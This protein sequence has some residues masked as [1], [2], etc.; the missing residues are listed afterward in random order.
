MEANFLMR[1]ALT[2]MKSEEAVEGIIEMFRRTKSNQEFIQ[3]IRK[4]K[5]V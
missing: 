2:G 4:T 3:T 5:I 1:K